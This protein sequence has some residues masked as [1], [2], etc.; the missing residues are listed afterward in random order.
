MQILRTSYSRDL[1]V[2]PG[3]SRAVPIFCNFDKVKYNI[4]IQMLAA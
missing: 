4:A 1:V 3:I 2:V